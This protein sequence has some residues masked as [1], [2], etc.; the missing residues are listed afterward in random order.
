[1]WSPYSAYFQFVERDLARRMMVITTVF[2][3]VPAYVFPMSQSPVATFR[4]SRSYSRSP[5]AFA[6]P[7]PNSQADSLHPSSSLVLQRFL[8]SADYSS[9]RSRQRPR[10]HD[11]FP[12]FFLI[13]PLMPQTES[14]P[15]AKRPQ[16]RKRLLSLCLMRATK[17][18]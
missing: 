7:G 4:S 15:F 13:A 14:T 18:T 16:V 3:L 2:P 6:T 17:S 9:G 11:C 12:G 5:L 8:V 1:M 10:K